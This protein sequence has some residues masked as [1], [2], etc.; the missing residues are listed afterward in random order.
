MSYITLDGT[1]EERE[2]AIA[3][4]GE[5][6]DDYGMVTKGSSFNYQQRTFVGM[7]PNISVKSEYNRHDYE[8]YRP[9][10]R[11]PKTQIDKVAACL[12][13]YDDFGIIRNVVDLMGDFGAQGVRIAHPNKKIEKFLQQWFK[14]VNG[15]ERS[16]MFLNL[17]Y[18]CG[19]I[20]VR[21]LEGK[22][23]LKTTK[24]WTKGDDSGIPDVEE[25]SLN[26]RTVPLK[27]IFYTPLAI[28]V[29]GGQIACFASK[30]MF[31]LKLS[32]IA[33]SIRNS[34]A[35]KDNLIEDIIKTLPNEIQEAVKRGSKYILLDQDNVSSYYYKKN[36]WDV[37]ATP[38]IAPILP[39]LYRLD[40][41]KLADM[42]ALDGIISSIRLWSVGVLD[43]VNSILPTKT[44]ISKLRNILANNISGG[45]M[46]LV[47]GPELSF[48][49][50]SSSSYNFLGE[51]KYKPT[52]DEIYRGV[53]IPQTLVGGG[54]AG[55]TNNYMSLKT[56]I[57]RLE[58]GRE[59]LV[60]FWNQELKRVQIAMGHS[61]P[62]III[63]DEM[64]LTDEASQNTLL[65]QMVDRNLISDETLRGR[66]KVNNEIEE[67]RIKREHNEKGKKMP[68]K[69][70][71]FHKPQIEDDMKKIALQS[72]DVT[73]SEV[74][75]ELKPRKQGEKTPNEKQIEIKK[76][77][78]GIK[79]NKKGGKTINGRP[80][81]SK[82]SEPRKQK[83][84]LPKTK[85]SINLLLW[86][87]SA[88]AKT[89]DI[90]SK[91][92]LDSLSKKN[93]RMLTDKEFDDLESLKFRVFSQIKPFEQVNEQKVYSILEG[94]YC[95]HSDIFH[96]STNLISDFI[97]FNKR[98]PTTEELRKI[99]V[100]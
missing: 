55:M 93:L 57:E 1:K 86:S 19:N 36:D 69:A 23:T 42:S 44:T 87:D 59:V 80:I 78:I 18:R 79:K 95:T 90:I 68:P 60:S 62:G 26:K 89:S 16:N 49:E 25:P 45:V 53:G 8:Y 10:E 15:K 64:V 58:Y 9:N 70:G 99:Q 92:V 22:I 73:P 84:I 50:S 75:L 3:L 31:A 2:K 12:K 72:G 40:K 7:E 28:E 67:V 24:L 88:Y 32:G 82:D 21:R 35:V 97:D 61:E 11:T 94:K 34:V 43:G 5:C 100:S 27:Y 66:I 48:K 71:Q 76:E 54:G 41:L 85:G 20:V 17:L 52:L 81:D 63:F 33:N 37:W 30:P 4:F 6:T 39:D 51:E 77:K 13:A 65:L 46:D 91:A 47:W 29:L 74:G 96:I 14:I 83:R 38:M 98:E 56:L